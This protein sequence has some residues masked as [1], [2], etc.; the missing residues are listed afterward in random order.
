MNEL[1]EAIGTAVEGALAS[2]AVERER[3]SL[4]GSSQDGT[5][6][7]LNCGTTLIGSHCHACGQKAKLHR[8][9]RSFLHDLL[10]GALHFEGKIWDTLPKLVTKPGE[11]TRRYIEGERARFVSPMALFLFTVFAMFAVF[12]IAGITTPTELEPFDE[13]GSARAEGALSTYED[14]LDELPP[15]AREERAEVEAAIE[16]VRQA[17]EDI[18]AG[19]DYSFPN[20]EGGRSY[21]R[22]N[23]TGIDAIDRGI[24]KKWRTNPGLMLYKLQTNFY[25]FSW[26]LIP[27]SIP[28]V[29]ILFFWK[30]RFRAYDHAVFVTYSLAFM[31]L[32]TI[33]LVLLGTLGVAAWIVWLA[34]TIIPP[35]HI[36]KQLR[37][38]YAL[39]RFSA[40]WRLCVLLVFIS[41]ILIVMMLLIV[42]LGGF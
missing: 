6:D 23:L 27:L 14:R 1:G 3:G 7:C 11:L 15:E 12:Q 2:R 36:Y 19:R 37:G 32:L 9:L 8:T 41:I 39:S 26:L 16:E 34:A 21:Q 24:L 25:K 13:R 4:S 31:T 18:E 22:F 30:R 17:L 35:I 10:H 29:W 42:L 40:A 28:F 38:A 33:G 20:P 5:Q